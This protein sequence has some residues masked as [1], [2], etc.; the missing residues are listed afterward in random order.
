[1][2]HTLKARRAFLTEESLSEME[3]AASFFRLVLA[4][5][6]I[7]HTRPYCAVLKKKKMAYSS[8]EI[9][10]QNTHRNKKRLIHTLLTHRQ[11][12]CVELPGSIQ[13]N[14][15]RKNREKAAWR[16]CLA[17]SRSEKRPPLSPESLGNLRGPSF[18]LP[19]VLVPGH[20]TFGSPWESG[21]RGSRRLATNMLKY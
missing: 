1:M 9:R 12:A 17:P 4:L 8:A 20:Y 21:Q 14:L 16:W 7:R 13:Q 6:L 3:P 15:I 2:L 5:A 19:T 18:P 10:L 11:R